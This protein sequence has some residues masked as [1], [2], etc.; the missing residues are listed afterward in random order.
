M[1]DALST[2]MAFVRVSPCAGGGIIV[3][4]ETEAETGVDVSG[5]APLCRWLLGC[6]PGAAM[7]GVAAGG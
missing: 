7:A 1:E 2:S 4:A 3:E 5:P 6:G